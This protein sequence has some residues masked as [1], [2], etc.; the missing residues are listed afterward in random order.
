VD[1]FAFGGGFASVPLMLHEVVDAR[2]WMSNRR[3]MD[4]IVLGRVTPG[5]IVITA[6]FVGYQVAGLVGA[7]IATVSIFTPSF[8][9]LLVTVPCFDRLVRS[10]VIQRAVRGAM[11]SFVGLLLSTAVQFGMATPW[12]ASTLSLAVLAFVAL[13]MRCSVEWVVL[14]GGAISVAVL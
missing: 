6:T 14:V 4:G 13:R 3:F 12:A 10:P 5:P 8:L 2:G 7:V 9:L 11:L 1:L